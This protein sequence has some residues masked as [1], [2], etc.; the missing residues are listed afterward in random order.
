MSK[1]GEMLRQAREAQKMTLDDIAEITKIRKDHLTALE[2]GRFEIFIAPIYIKGFVRSYAQAVKL[3]PQAVM[4]LVD[5]E[6]RKINKFKNSTS[7]TG[8][9]KG[10][11]DWVMFQ[12]SKV[13]WEIVLPVLG[14]IILLFISYNLYRVYQQ[15]KSRDIFSEYGV[16]TYQPAPEKYELYLPVPSHPPQ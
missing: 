3:D 1:V 13:H 4:P 8:R 15:H 11:L 5:E 2:E 9:K 12:L 6:L 16:N 14:I 7:I 10:A